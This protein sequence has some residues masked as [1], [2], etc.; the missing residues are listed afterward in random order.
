MLFADVW[1][2]SLEPLA[3]LT[4]AVRV[5]QVR[6]LVDLEKCFLA[7]KLNEP[8]LAYHFH[9]GKTSKNNWLVDVPHTRLRSFR[10]KGKRRFEC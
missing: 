2:D 10:K 5:I 3:V 4:Q 7:D 1:V 8:L 9:L 6:Y